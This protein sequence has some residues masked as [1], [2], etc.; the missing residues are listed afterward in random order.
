MIMNSSKLYILNRLTDNIFY[1]PFKLKPQCQ[2]A[3][4]LDFDSPLAI[5]Y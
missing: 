3:Y 4:K 1:N 2:T 5:R